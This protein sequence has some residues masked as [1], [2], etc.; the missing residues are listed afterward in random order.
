MFSTVCDRLRD[1]I[2]APMIHTRKRIGVPATRFSDRLSLRNDPTPKLNLDPAWRPKL[3]RPRK[4][5]PLHHVLVI[6][7]NIQQTEYGRT[8]PRRFCES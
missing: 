2:G 3:K 6:L 5:L 8:A 7:A 1:A 4:Q